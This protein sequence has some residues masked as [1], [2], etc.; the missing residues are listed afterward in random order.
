[1]VKQKLNKLFSMSSK[2]IFFRIKEGIEEKTE[3]IEY[4][5]GAD[6]RFN[7]LLSLKQNEKTRDKFF[8]EAFDKTKRAELIKKSISVEKRLRDADN[9][10]KGR[11]H[12][13]GKELELAYPGKWNRDP[14]TGIAWPKVFYSKINR[15]GV[16]EKCDIKHVWEMNRHQFLIILGTA[17][18][19]TGNE[20]YAEKASQ[21][22]SD[23][24]DDNRYN[25]GVN[26]TSSLE[27]AVRAISWIWTIHLC[28]ESN[29]FK[30]DLIKKIIRSL[31]QHGKYIEKHLSVFSSPYNHLIGEIAALHLIG[32][33]FPQI[34]NAEKWETFGWSALED[35]IEK[36][37]YPDGMSV[38]QAS[39][40]HHFTLGF[41]LQAVLLRRLNNKPISKKV[42]NRLEK[43][44]EFSFYLVMPDGT[45]PMIGDVDNARSLYFSSDHSWDF[46][47]FLSL[48]A[49]LFNRADFKSVC[50]GMP[51]EALWL[52]KDDDLDYYV[53]MD[54]NEP[55]KKSAS[56]PRSGYFIMRNAWKTD[57]SYLCFDCGEIADGLSS[58]EI[59]SAAHGHADALSFNL[60]VFGKPFLIDG[61]FC[62]YFGD[63]E[64]HRYFRH[65]E[66][67]NTLKIGNNRQADFCGRLKWQKVISPELITWQ[68]SKEMDYA[69]GKIRYN[70]N[71]AHERHI[72]YL[73][74]RLWAVADYVFISPDVIIKS[75]FNFDPDVDI[76]INQDDKTIRAIH[77]KNGNRGLI[78]KFFI[79]GD[80]HPSKGGEGPSG[81]WIA[82]G[83]G[84]KDE[85][86]R[87][88]I[89][90]KSQ[91]STSPFPFLIIPWEENLDNIQFEQHHDI[92]ESESGRFK[93][94]FT[95]NNTNYNFF[96]DSDRKIHIE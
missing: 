45:L 44:L 94:R 36:Q 57:S 43:A 72:L 93:I 55:E 87:T 51:E 82:R 23:W 6:I 47:G 42:L 67:H 21:I 69:A 27:L 13:L 63:Y 79:D 37:F 80:I 38:E 24:I 5:T 74:N 4:I 41:Y 39:F 76:T 81:G 22:I 48:G 65:E 26:W 16:R 7:H 83:Y 78:L 91:N 96:S 73:K 3:Y 60:S 19:L 17:Y 29:I 18:W 62:T 33:L 11:L 15:T 31:Y 35:Q 88:E 68:T 30:D 64:W 12:F 59:P 85:A 28:R 86:W 8:T 70:G 14:V 71:A 95:I 25:C 61:G 92:L 40:Y 9:I 50:K 56:F 89:T 84:M 90:W 58:A 34:R 75:F 66:A 49:V 2:E 53:N 46:R 32:S 20:K 54:G 52:L 1:M 77:R 10:C